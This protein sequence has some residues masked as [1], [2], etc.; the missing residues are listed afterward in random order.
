MRL[1]A[2]QTHIAAILLHIKTLCGC[3]AQKASSKSRWTTSKSLSIYPASMAPRVE[4]AIHH[5]QHVKKAPLGF[6]QRGVFLRVT[7]TDTT[8]P[9]LT[10][11]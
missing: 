10:R 1:H 2:S 11:L 9:I 3:T 5:Q 7:D 8:T 6:A 4:A